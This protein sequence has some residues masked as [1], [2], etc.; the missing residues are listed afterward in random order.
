MKKFLTDFKAFILRGNV[1]DM[2]IGIVVGAAFT[3]IITSLVND[4]IMPVI[5]AAT[6]G[7]NFK[8]LKAVISEAVYDEAG[9]VIK[10]ET[11]VSYGAFV[12]NVIYFLIIALMCFITI[13]I[14]TGSLKKAEKLTKAAAG[15]LL[16]NNKEPPKAEEK[17]PPEP[18]EQEK[19]L[20]EIRDLLKE[21]K[22]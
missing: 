7:I 11:A 21:L 1:I 22:K 2:A 3:A 9:N 8:D 16:K 5:G 13:R 18:T 12:Q 6:A 19:L 17:K 10:A 15:K 4:I 20:I 14:L